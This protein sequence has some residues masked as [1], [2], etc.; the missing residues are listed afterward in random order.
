MNEES[1]QGI[2][3]EIEKL[4]SVLPSKAVVSIDEIDA[5]DESIKKYEEEVKSL[6]EKLSNKDNYQR[7]KSDFEVNERPVIE[8]LLQES[9]ATQQQE[10]QDEIAKYKRLQNEQQK[11]LE[12]YKKSVEKVQTEIQDIQRR[13][14]RN[15][16]A[17]KR[18]YSKLVLSDTELDSLEKELVDKQELLELGTGLIKVCEDNISSYNKNIDECNEKMLVLNKKEEKLTSIVSSKKDYMSDV[19]KYAIRLDEDKL[20]KLES[21]LTALKNQKFFLETDAKKLTQDKLAEI[22]ENINGL[23]NQLATERTNNKNL[24]AQIEELNKTIQD[25]ENENKLLMEENKK[26]KQE[27]PQV[28][29]ETS[30]IKEEKPQVKEESNVNKVE[31][32]TNKSHKVTKITSAKEFLKKHKKEIL[33]AAG[34]AAVALTAQPYI[35][36]AIMHANSVLWTSAPALRGFLHGCN[37]VLGKTIGASYV[38]SSGL[39]TA[40]SGALINASAAEASLLGALAIQATTIGV[41]GTSAKKLVSKIQEKIKKKNENVAPTTENSNSNITNVEDLTD[42]EDLTLDPDN[43]DALKTDEKIETP[44]NS[45]KEREELKNK[46]QELKKSLQNSNLGEYSNNEELLKE[47]GG[48]TL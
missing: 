2:L 10:I 3:A 25:K 35:I 38:G 24:Q 1:M 47:E 34:V 26:M 33:I 41:I 27:V 11:Y 6:S 20:A 16:V 8:Q 42:V 12:E 15:E 28:K 17:Q 44:T 21:G 23:T 40:A 19:D 48:K 22:K 32:S 46:L 36:P 45:E 9:I 7:Q 30:Q 31:P 18:N 13:L 14:Y 39:W 29:Q 5:I 43:I 4:V 37:L